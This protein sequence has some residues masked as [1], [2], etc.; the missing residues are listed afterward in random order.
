M[1]TTIDGELVVIQDEVVVHVFER[2][3]LSRAAYTYMTAWVQK[4]TVPTD[5]PDTT[6]KR[7]EEAWD[8]LSPEIQASL[9][10]ISNK[11]KQNAE[12]IRDGLLATLHGYQGFT[13]VKKSFVEAIQAC[14]SR[15]T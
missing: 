13:H 8:A 2:Y 5:D 10:Q 1:Y 12:D 4:H 11:E 9:W 14:F 6:W 7:A 3:N 15:L